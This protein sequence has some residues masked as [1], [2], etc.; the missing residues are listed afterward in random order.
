MLKTAKEIRAAILDGSTTAQTVTEERLK[1]IHAEDGKIGAF[2]ETFDDEA[3]ARAKEIDAMTVEAKNELPLCGVPIAIK[4]NMLFAGHIASAGANILAEHRATYTGTAVQRLMDAGAIIIGRTNMD[5]AAMGSST[6]T[7]AFQK[8]YNPVDMTKIPGGS[9]GGSAAAV[10]AG[11]VPIAFGS[12]TG[13]SIRQPAAMCGVV[14]MKPSYGR[15]SRYG[16]IALC[17]SFDQI[18]PLTTTVEDAALALRIIE[19]QDVQDATT[20]PLRDT[21]VPELLDGSLK[22]VRVGVPKEYFIEGMDLE[23]EVTVKQAIEKMRAAGAE[24]VEISLPLTEYALPTY[25]IIQPAEASSN[26][27]RYE[28]IRYGTRAEGKNL[29]ETYLNA[30][31]A[32]FGMEVKRRIM[33]GTFILSAGYYD[34]YYKKALAVKTAIANDLKEAF[35]HVDVIATPTSPCVAW[36]V[37][38]MMDDPLAMYLAD[39]FTVTANVAGIPGISVPCG[40][41]RGLPVGLQFL[42]PYMGEAKMLNAAKA[43]EEIAFR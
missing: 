36:N 22:G 39:I 19:G 32:G 26:L 43:F 29:E 38:D 2:L 12:D 7:S 41:V 8:T 24:I 16:L 13:G 40:T 1:K 15:V 35:K 14:G 25:Y 9:S 23:V 4:D 27:E 5:D 28:G 31:G 10:A 34:A 21:V 30:R 33:L 11:F 20:V 17:S 18:G 42:G 3:I 37:G 6:E